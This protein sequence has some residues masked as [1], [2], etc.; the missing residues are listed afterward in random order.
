[1]IIISIFIAGFYV[2]LMLLLIIGRCKLKAFNFE[3]L[4]QINK[5]SIIIPFRDEAKN[6]EILLQSLSKLN[7]PKEQFEI[8]LVNDFSSDNF[9]PIIDNFRVLF[10]N[11]YCVNSVNAGA[12]PKKTALSLGIF[13]AKY[14]WIITTD[15]DCTFSK[16][17]LNSINQK[18]VKDKP[19][20]IAGLV[21]FNLKKGLLNHFQCLD[22][23]SLQATLLGTFGWQKPILCHGANLCYSK[24]LFYELNGFSSHHHIASG[25]DVFLLEAAVAKYPDKVLVLNSLEGVV[26]T[27]AEPTINALLSQRMRWAAKA[28][29]YHNW[30]T[31]IVGLIVFAMSLLMIT[32]GILSLFNMF[33]VKLFFILLLIKFIIDA[34]ILFPMAHFFK[35]KSALKSFVFSS[36]L[37]P[38]FSVTSVMLGF[39]KIY[40]WK[41]RDFKI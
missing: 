38:L 16:N 13:N 40:T 29:S 28:T 18:I 24:S 14:N 17:W 27:N 39:T 30:I 12:S 23:L 9:M 33:D 32:S 7:Y 34:L 15:A 41:N 8:I 11:L 5:F 2:L 31:K 26:S 10:P 35:Q 3:P 4:P 1:M 19:L 6:L 37:Y 21:K 20:M 22:L 36:L 25:D